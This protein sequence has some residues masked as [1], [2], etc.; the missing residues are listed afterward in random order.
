MTGYTKYYF[1]VNDT[2]SKGLSFNGDVTITLGDTTLTKDT[3]Y[4]VTATEHADGTT[5]VEI[6][7]KNFI[8]YKNAEKRNITI[9]TLF[10]SP[11]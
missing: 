10:I 6:V 1:V 5:S 3:D 9:G 7:F 11:G 4:A 8:Q 2:L